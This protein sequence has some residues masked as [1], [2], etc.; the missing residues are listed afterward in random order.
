MASMLGIVLSDNLITLF[1]FW[2]LTSLS[3]YFLIG[4]DH[5]RDQARYA[6]WQALLVTGL[7]GLA[8]LAGLLLLGMSAGTYALGELLTRGDAIREDQ[9][10][11][12]ILLLIAVGAFTKSAQFPFYFWLPNA[13]EAP[14]PVSAY[15]HSATM[16]NAGVYL[17]ARLSPVLDAT[18]A[19]TWLIGGVGAA[20]MLVGAYPAIEQ[21]HVKRVLAYSTVS[22]LGMMTMLL[23]LGGETGAV[24][25][26]AFLLAHALYKATLF[27]VAGSVDH[28]TGEREIDNLGGLRHAMPFTALAAGAGALS[29]AGVPFFFG[30]V[31]KEAAYEAALH[32]Q[33]GIVAATSIILLTSVS[34]VVVACI[35]AHKL[36][37]G[38]TKTG[39]RV[40]S[41]APWTMWLGPVVLAVAGLVFGLVPNTVSRWLVEP[42]AS[43]V[44]GAPAHFEVH[45]TGGP[46][47]LWALSIAALAVGAFIYANRLSFL[48]LTS[49][50][51]YLARWGPR[52]GYDAALA[53]MNLTARVQTRIL[54][55]GY[56]R[57]Y[58]MAIIAMMLFLVWPALIVAGQPRIPGGLGLPRLHESGLA[59]IMV[60]AI[61]ATVFARSRLAAIA[62]LS[63]TGFSVGLVYVL[64][65]APDLAM[66][67]F[68]IETLYLILYML[69]FYRLPRY[70]TH[71]PDF[72]RVRDAVFAVITG[73][74]V[75]ALVLAAA[76]L[77]FAPTISD[78]Y[79]EHG[80]IAAHGRNVVNVI[81]VDFRGFDT[82]G[83]IT[84]LAVA[85][86]G[87][88][89]LLK[90]RTRREAHE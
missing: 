2:E 24:A 38:E 18:P 9:L 89:A 85:G 86:I 83:E 34:F 50:L 74:L 77:Q 12:A 32:S 80:P 79:M 73:A 90:L 21:S 11:T 37:W 8:L 87:A 28:Q 62:A 19:W 61:G 66:T 40:P 17:L 26:T 27:L 70:T 10:Y 69:A 30:F 25:A 68:V 56:L 7:G 55:H 16:V 58:L 53:G 6:A 72:V 33:S 54:Q 67:Q 78:Y 52:H 49:P 41:E 43:A 57:F 36:F 84:V 60:M 65:G 15:L 4:F 35:M 22:A 88:F 48:R 76:N 42:A 64:F 14:T 29:M 13:M 44:R 81:L 20:T 51:L 82:M 63:L 5:E 1:I 46:A 45:L 31:G 23:G 47:L 71:S 3:S 39:Q 59:L 75:T